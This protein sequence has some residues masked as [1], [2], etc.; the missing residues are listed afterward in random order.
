MNLHRAAFPNH[1]RK[2]VAGLCTYEVA[3]LFTQL[4]TLSELVRRRR[5]LGVGLL[6]LLAHHWFLE[7]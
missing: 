2:I 7:R 6:G 1:G 3:A 4:P 5:L